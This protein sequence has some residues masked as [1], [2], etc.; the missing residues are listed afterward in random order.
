MKLR[1]NVLASACLFVVTLAACAGVGEPDSPAARATTP[2]P[3]P[4]PSST[5]TPAPKPSPSEPAPPEKLLTFAVVGD[6]GTGGVEQQEI[7]DRM[8]RYHRKHTFDLVVTTGDNVYPAGSPDDFETAFFRPYRCLH[9]RDVRFRA[10]LGNH[11]YGTRAGAPEL[12]EPAFGMKGRNYVVQ[13][14]GVRLV[15]VDSNYL[16]R[17]WLQEAIRPRK[18]VV[19]TIVVFHHPVHSVGSVHGSTASFSDLPP[20]FREAGVDLVLNGHDHIYMATKPKRGIRYVVTGGGGAA[21]YACG[22][23]AY[24]AACESRHHF[25]FVRVFEDRI[26]LRAVPAAGRPFHR[27]KT[28]GRAP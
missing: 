17:A 22:D 28:G 7:A 11:D 1:A 25:S 19:F 24:V 13:R 26:E 10:V 14:A 12:E 23:A 20:M 5:P 3:T 18:R 9:R 8:C 16:D 15:M 4:T 6:F 21:L 2:A 27:F